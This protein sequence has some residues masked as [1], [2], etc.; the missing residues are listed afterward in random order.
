MENKFAASGKIVA[1]LAVFL[2]ALAC[3]KSSSPERRR[4]LTIWK[5]HYLVVED[6]AY[7]RQIDVAKFQ[8]ACAF[9]RRIAGISIPGD[10]SIFAEWLPSK[11]TVKVLGPL[12]R[13]YEGHKDQLYWDAS[14][15]VVILKPGGR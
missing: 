8:D 4:A 7:G 14:N 6:A 15:K 11:E 9:F 1:A 2:I 13:W 12:H 3:A 10:P 5:K